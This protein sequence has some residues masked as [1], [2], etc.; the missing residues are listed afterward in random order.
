MR[1]ETVSLRDGRSVVIRPG[2][3][4]DAAGILEN[5]NGIRKEEVFLLRDEVSDDLEKERSWIREF[6][7]VR[8]VLFVAAWAGK[9]VGQADCHGGSFEKDRHAGLIGIAIRDGWREIGLGRA[10]MDRVLA[11]MRA[12]GF[13]KAHLTVFSTNTRAIRLYESLGFSVEG[14]RK[15]AYRI[16]GEYAD[17]VVMGLW[18]GD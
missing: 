9:I 7:G 10:L 17:D 18:L 15:R 4:A 16:R 14:V 6:D 13:R 1:P 2:T 8:N 5:V 3:E 11:W 12:L